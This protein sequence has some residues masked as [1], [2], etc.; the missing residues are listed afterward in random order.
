MAKN[1]VPPEPKLRHPSKNRAE[2]VIDPEKFLT[3]FPVLNS[4]EI[5][6]QLRLLYITIGGDEHGR[7]YDVFKSLLDSKGVKY[8]SVETPGYGHDFAFW[9]LNLRDFA[10]RLF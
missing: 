1:S 7:P 3:V 5:N 8:T 10:A 6:S 9:R 2:P 4:S